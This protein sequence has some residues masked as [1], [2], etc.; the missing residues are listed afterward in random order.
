MSDVPDVPDVLRELEEAVAELDV[1]PTCR[2]LEQLFS[3]I[4]RL[5]AKAS[6]AS[7]L[8]DA[9]RDAAPSRGLGGRDR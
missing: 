1:Q 6:S 5:K 7:A 8:L 9:G 4:D 2:E 3:I